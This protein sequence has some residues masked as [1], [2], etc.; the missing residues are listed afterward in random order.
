MGIY[1]QALSFLQVAITLITAGIPSAISKLIAETK[2]QKHHIENIMISAKFLIICF[3]LI[4]IIFFILISKFIS[5]KFYILILPAAILIG[6]SSVINGFFL[7]IQETTPLRCSI[8]INSASTFV[9][10]S[11]ARK[12]DLFLNL[13]GKTQG[14]ITAILIGELTSFII[15]ISFY[16]KAKKELSSFKVYNLKELSKNIKHILSI[17]IPISTSQI[18]NSI[19]FSCKAM[20]IPKCLQISG[21]TPSD[22]LS[23]FGKTSGMVMPLLFF[24][25]IFTISLSSNIIPRISYVLS[26]NNFNSAFNLAQKSIVITTCFSLF[27]ASFFIVFS[28]PIADLLFNKNLVEKLISCFAIGIPFFYT[29][30]I[31]LALLRG[32]GDNKTP[33]LN[34]I[35][36]FLIENILIVFLVSKPNFRIY[37]YIISLI[38][39]S[40]TCIFTSFNALEK[41]FNRKF[42]CIDILI[43][44]LLCCC[45]MSFILV[46]INLLLKTFKLPLILYI[47]SA[48]IL[49]ASSYI[50]TAKILG[51]IIR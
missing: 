27:F 6:F 33:L 25:A 38:I 37:G 10:F 11:I 5:S 14:A 16:I 4:N 46:K 51:I 47:I 39:S 42:S 26:K 2:I 35:Y 49:G 36:S 44:P 20:L 19:S 50:I 13:E 8:L 28:K 21:L 1:E 29:E 32:I 45:F 41:N 7:G 18:I 12:S 24:P 17:A 40:A 15:L 34:S 22:A 23:V 31:L 48:F 3:S 43:K 30:N 9:F